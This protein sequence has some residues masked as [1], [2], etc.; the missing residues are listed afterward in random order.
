MADESSRGESQ[1]LVVQ[2]LVPVYDRKGRPYP[3]SVHKQI[4]R[5]LEDHF[6]GW[7]LA[8][9]RPLTGA[10]R[11]PESGEVEYDD[12]WRYEVGIAPD[13]LTELDDYL[14][15]LSYRLGQKALWRVAYAGGEGKVVPARAPARR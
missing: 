2:F 13:R 7:S 11:N 4:R 5:D 9:D 10:W 12:S 6:D 3:R 14:A 8:A 15:A 1:I